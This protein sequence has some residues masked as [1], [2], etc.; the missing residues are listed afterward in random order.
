MFCVTDL[1]PHLG[2]DQ[3]KRTLADGL[4]GEELN[5]VVGSLPY[6]DK[7]AERACQAVYA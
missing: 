4:R 1:L 5:I 2:A 6:A 7:E 3:N